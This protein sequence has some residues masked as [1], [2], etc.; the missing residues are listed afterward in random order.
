MPMLMNSFLAGN[1]QDTNNIAIIL[2]ES[3]DFPEKTAILIEQCK[4]L[5]KVMELAYCR[6]KNTAEAGLSL[7]VSLSRTDP[8]ESVSKTLSD[9][10]VASSLFKV[11]TSSSSSSYC[12]ILAAQWYSGIYSVNCVV[13]RICT[14]TSL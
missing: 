7:L 1:L 4:V 8:T 11:M 13:R 3:C 14:E 9:R 10:Q 12:K 2:A 6:V 5:P